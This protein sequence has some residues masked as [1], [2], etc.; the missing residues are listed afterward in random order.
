[1]N[2]TPGKT[3]GTFKTKDFEIFH[4]GTQAFFGSRSC[5]GSS[6]DWPLPGFPDLDI[7]GVSDDDGFVYFTII[8]TSSSP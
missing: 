2:Q 1:M 6:D 7:L 8:K 3:K 5:D 4:F